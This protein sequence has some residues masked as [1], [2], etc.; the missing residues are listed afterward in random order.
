MSEVQILRDREQIAEG[1]IGYML[2]PGGDA[3]VLFLHG[4]G[5]SGASFTEAFE[6]DWFDPA[7]TLLAPDLPG[8]GDSPRAPGYSYGLGL[9]ANA[10]IE[11]LEKR[12]AGD[13]VVIAH[14]MGNIVGLEI[15]R[16]L[17]RL[18]AYYCLEGNLV[19]S[20]CQISKRIA[21]YEE[22]AFRDR[23]Y[24]MA[25]QGLRCPGCGEADADPVALYR[26][27]VSLVQHC[28][29]DQPLNQFLELPVPKAYLYGSRNAA[30]PVLS[31]LA[32]VPLLE[33]PEAGHFLMNDAPHVVWGEIA[34]RIGSTA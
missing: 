18:V 7:L 20:D 23:F 11:F 31:H 3:H 22:R 32:Q 26:S 27:A 9:Q 34:R 10:V 16:A 29:Q 24:A 8:H 1:P 30:M 21:G 19:A 5:C 33:V 15:A 25:R 17:P 6:G 2:R 14:S 4:L 13:L 28:A 12:S